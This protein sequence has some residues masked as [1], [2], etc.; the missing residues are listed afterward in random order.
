VRDAAGHQLL[1]QGLQVNRF[2]KAA[3]KLTMNL[4]S[5]AN[6]GIRPRIALLFCSHVA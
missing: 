2:E 1:G 5:R 4:H 6:D 3:A